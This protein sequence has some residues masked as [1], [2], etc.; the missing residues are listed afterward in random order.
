L[1]VGGYSSR[2]DG[3]VVGVLG[4]SRFTFLP[5][6]SRMPVGSIFVGDQVTW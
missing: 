2:F 3:N 4:G 6:S 1:I 5:G